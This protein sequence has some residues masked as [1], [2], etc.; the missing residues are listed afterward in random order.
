[1]GRTNMRKL[2]AKLFGF[3]K[4]IKSMSNKFNELSTLVYDHACFMD[5]NGIAQGVY[6]SKEVEEKWNKFYEIEYEFNK[7]KIG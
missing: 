3:D 6:D 2:I 4:Q 5:S 7:L 1:M